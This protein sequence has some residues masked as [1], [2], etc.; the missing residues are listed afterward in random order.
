MF[1]YKV[2]T[3]VGTELIA[4]VFYWA[5]NILIARME[6][7]VSSVAELGEVL[8]MGFFNVDRLGRAQLAFLHNVC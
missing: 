1:N 8:I 6:Q 2:A 5:S 7:I 3:I 4:G